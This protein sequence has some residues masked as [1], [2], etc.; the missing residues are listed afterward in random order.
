MHL[1]AVFEAAHLVGRQRDVMRPFALE[2]GAGDFAL[3]PCHRRCV[4]ISL[5]AGISRCFATLSIASRSSVAST[6][7]SQMALCATRKTSQVD[8][9]GGSGFLVMRQVSAAR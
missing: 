9:G 5:A 1:L 3:V 2:V 6:V 7:P 8:S 4:A